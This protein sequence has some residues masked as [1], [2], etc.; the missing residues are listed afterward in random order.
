MGILGWGPHKWKGQI[1]TE[2]Y[3]EIIGE[4][5]SPVQVEWQVRIAF[6]ST[7]RW[8]INERLREK[9]NYRGFSKDSYHFF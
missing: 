1:Y 4:A 9:K 6:V 2:I 5:P 3:R 8:S 7:K